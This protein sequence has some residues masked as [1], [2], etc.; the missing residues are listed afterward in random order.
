MTS[1][2]ISRWPPYWG[3]HPPQKLT[4]R[5]A[6][7]HPKPTIEI[8]CFQTLTIELF[9]C[10]KHGACFERLLER[11]QF[12][13]S[14]TLITIDLEL[15]YILTRWVYHISYGIFCVFTKCPL[16]A[17]LWIRS[18][19][20]SKGN[21]VYSHTINR[22]TDRTPAEF[23]NL[24]TKFRLKPPQSLFDKRYFD[25]NYLE[26]QTTKPTYYLFHV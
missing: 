13:Y 21:N 7:F 11:W 19:P 12:L 17:K 8:W 24:R 15:W 3:S 18:G 14:G 1:N 20:I 2:E 23:N 5:P 9:E 25:C 10:R 16:V 26:S 22:P 6:H 4:K